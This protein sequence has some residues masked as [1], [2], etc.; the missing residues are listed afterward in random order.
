MAESLT[1]AGAVVFRKGD[2]D[3][4][5]LVVSSSDGANWVLP[6]GHIDPGETPEVAALRELAEE[7][8]VVGV[9][10]NPLALRQFEK[11]GK[12]VTVQYFLM[13]ENGSTATT[14][15]RVVRWEDKRAALQ[16]LSFEEAR[17][18]LIEGAASERTPKSQS[19]S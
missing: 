13:R 1:H 7:A 14:E 18:A 8:G 19:G 5:Y 9:I 10:V 3:T 2:K 16:L 12:Q 4:L 11:R 17:L 15:K 6:K